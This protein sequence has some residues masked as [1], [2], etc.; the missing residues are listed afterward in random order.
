[1]TAYV[2][3]H[4]A[5]TDTANAVIPVYD[6]GVLYGEGVYEVFRK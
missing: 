2:N 1:M 3:V 4:G 6:H 5:I